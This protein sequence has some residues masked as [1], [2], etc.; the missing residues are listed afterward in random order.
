MTDGS[1]T[2][3]GDAATAEQ[4]LRLAEEYH[5]AAEILLTQ[6]RRG[7]PLSRAPCRH[8]AIHAIELYLNAILLRNGYRASSVRGLQHDFSAKTERAIASGLKLRKRTEE[9][10]SALNANREYLV[11]RYGPEMTSTASQLNRLTAT[12]NEVARKV[13]AIVKAA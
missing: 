8:T 11:S 12:L 6:G 2:Y 5:R 13:S 7:E 10:I 3:P 1:K 9:H 4:L